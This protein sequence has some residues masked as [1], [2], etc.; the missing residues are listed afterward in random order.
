MRRLE[1]IFKDQDE[2]E[3]RRKAIKKALKIPGARVVGNTVIR[4]TPNGLTT[5]SS[6]SD[7]LN[8]F[9]GRI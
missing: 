1:K 4:R 6:I 3:Q 9:P 2:I 8:Q 7:F 5:T